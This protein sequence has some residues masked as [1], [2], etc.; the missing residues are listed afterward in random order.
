MVDGSA[1]LMAAPEVS[2]GPGAAV[3]RVRD[4]ASLAALRRTG[5]RARRGP[6]AVSWIPAPADVP[7]RVAFA[8]P[9]RS[10]GAVVRNRIR[11]RLRAACAALRRDGRL[12]AGTYLLVGEGELARLPWVELV[13][14]VERT[15]RAAIAR[16]TP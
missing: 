15:T 12:A 4:R 1:L 10:G 6:L 3:W 2:P 8:I 9:R 14:L 11:R 7:P 5:A 13:E 16:G